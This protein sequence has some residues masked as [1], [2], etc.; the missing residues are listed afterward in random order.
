[1]IISII[2]VYDRIIVTV[3]GETQRKFYIVD[4]YA[5]VYVDAN[6]FSLFAKDTNAL[7]Y[8]HL[9]ATDFITPTGTASQILTTLGVNFV[10]DNG[11]PTQGAYLHI[12]NN[13]TTVWNVWHNLNKRYIHVTVIDSAHTE[14]FADVNYIDNNHLQITFGADSSGWAY[15]S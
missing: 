13:P 2:K 4:V 12:E 5:V 11:T 1:M 8:E 7:L 10:A 14:I 9:R 6:N 3:P 15:I